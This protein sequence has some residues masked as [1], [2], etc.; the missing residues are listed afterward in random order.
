MTLGRTIKGSKSGSRNR[1]SESW[2][3]SYADL[4]TNLL[5]LFVML[6]VISKGQFKES[7]SLSAQKAHAS[8]TAQTPN[9]STT[10]TPSDRDRVAAVVANING[11]ISPA[12][13]DSDK[14]TVQRANEGL[15]VNF[16]GEMLFDSGSAALRQESM[17][18]LAMVSGLLL[19]LPT[20]FVV[21]VEGHTDATPTRS[22]RYPSNWE[23]SSARAGSVVRALQD[24]GFPADR[25][26]A[27]GF[28]DTQPVGPG[29][30]GASN[31]RVVLRL[32]VREESK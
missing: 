2:I 27:V 32:K 18:A 21:D 19:T 20:G 3:Y 17:P 15:K 16:G 5:A 29:A 24:F 4:V 10:L 28:A 7:K 6:L 8:Q 13:V 26:R 1:D 12:S 23:L 14:V 31:R 30:E 25:M 11:Q 9:D 22:G